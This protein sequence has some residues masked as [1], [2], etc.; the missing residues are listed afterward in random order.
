[1]QNIL[2]EL[3]CK[4]ETFE[5]SKYGQI[6]IYVG[7][8]LFYT[9]LHIPNILVIG[10]FASSAFPLDSLYIAEN[11]LLPGGKLNHDLVTTV[12]SPSN[13]ILITLPGIYLLCSILG[14]VK[15]IFLLSFIVQSIVPVLSY[16]LYRSISSPLVSL[17][18]SI[19]SSYYF[20]D[21]TWWSPD[22][23]IQPLIITGLLILL[24]SLNRY[25]IIELHKLLF[26]GLLTGIVIILKH[27][28]GIFWGVLVVSF[29]LFNSIMF[30][31]DKR[32]IKNRLL[33][34]GLFFGFF[35]FGFYFISKLIHEDEIVYYLFPYFAFYGSVTYYT[36]K[37]KS[38]GFDLTSF[39]NNVFSFSI[40]A[41][42]LPLIIFLWMGSAVGYARYL[43]SFGMG[44]KYLPIWDHGIAGIMGTYFKLQNTFS[45]KN[46]FLN[47]NALILAILFL[48]PFAVNLLVNAKLFLLIRDKTTGTE[49][50]KKYFEIASL[51][52]MG[53]FMLFP[54]EGYHILST[55]LFIFLVIA[56]YVL[57]NIS[58]KYSM[59]LKSIMILMIIP[60]V[61]YAVYQPIALSRIETSYG[62]PKV[63]K[64]IGMPMEKKLADELSKQVAVIERATH[65]SPY[66]V[67][68][69]AGATLASLMAI[70]NNNYPQYYL[71]MRKGI[72]NQEV[73]DA[74]IS[75]V[76]KVPFVLVNYDDY[77][78]YLQEQQ[79][80]PYMTQILDYIQKNYTI[81]DQYEESKE[82][83]PS[84]SQ[85]HSFLIM[86]KS[87]V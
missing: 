60:V 4:L 29:L 81:V 17:L 50:L 40:A 70:E 31:G 19:F 46:I 74:I 38:I 75:S 2:K 76:Q 49:N 36:F 87:T 82:Q 44:L 27:N 23:L 48:V 73:T 79:D 53:V 42:I 5:S 84:I 71:E 28:E 64:A 54:L 56:L 8:L 47:Y 58:L 21:T 22:F 41:L 85:I 24:S 72:M 33:L 3:N 43:S 7:L 83:S 12:V 32:F 68:D 78:K 59:I 80:D 15:N 57:R 14:N 62:S 13:A 34:F 63:E 26:I 86:K 10:N 55:K 18:V 61:L 37:N 67:I 39:L 35:A 16:K 51:G 30:S 52:I 45:L 9:V 69:S 77:Q 66:Y 25:N 11:L 65:G 6:K 20:L 1:M